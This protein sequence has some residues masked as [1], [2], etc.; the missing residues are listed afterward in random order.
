MSVELDSERNRG[1]A[2]EALAGELQER[3]SAADTRIAQQ[4]EMINK[5]RACV[6]VRG[7]VYG[8]GHGRMLVPGK[9]AGGLQG[10]SRVWMGQGWMTNGVSLGRDQ[11]GV[12]CRAW[13]AARLGVRG[14]VPT[15]PG[16]SRAVCQLVTFEVQVGGWKFPWGRWRRTGEGLEAG[17]QEAADTGTAGD[18]W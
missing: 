17:A 11:R 2:A 10:A 15:V 4:D 18:T 9:R 14:A 16:W 3:I 7:C 6:R 5:V 8:G 1:D 12:R 13:E